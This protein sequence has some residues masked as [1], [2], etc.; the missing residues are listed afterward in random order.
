MAAD[1]VGMALIPYYDHLMGILRTNPELQ[2]TAKGMFKQVAWGAA[3]TV[4]GAAVGG[5]F[6]AMVGGIAGSLIGYTRSDDYQSLIGVMED[7]TEE[8]KQEISRKVQ[9][10]VGGSSI[11]ALTR[12]IG[13]QAQRSALLNLLRSAVS[14]MAK[15]G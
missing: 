15:G 11:E 7:L 4:A 6:G 2:K 3:G 12:Y 8:D 13:S 14:E 5:P 1:I 10:L 9:E